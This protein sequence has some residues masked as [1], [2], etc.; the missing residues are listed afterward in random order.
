MKS[1]WHVALCA[2][3][4]AFAFAPS[5]ANPVGSNKLAGSEDISFRKASKSPTD[6]TEVQP[7][8][9]SFARNDAAPRGWD[10]GSNPRVP[11]HANAQWNSPASPAPEPNALVL[12]AVGLVIVY[13]LRRRQRSKASR[14][15][16]DAK[17]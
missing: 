12:S 4:L 6:G 8:D 14:A 16:A 1:M 7:T 10:T 9:D 3:T 15:G 5:L 17:E 2:G 13:A 11:E